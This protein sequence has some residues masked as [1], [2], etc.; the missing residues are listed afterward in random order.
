MAKT[1]NTFGL[2]FLTELL[3]NEPRTYSALMCCL[4]AS[5]KKKVV[6]SKIEFIMN[7][8]T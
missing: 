3:E 5:Y 4:E 2:N 8:H 7:N 1:T 6:N